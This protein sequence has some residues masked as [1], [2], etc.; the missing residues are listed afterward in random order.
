MKRVAAAGAA[1]A[2]VYVA[3]VAATALFTDRDVRPLFDAIGPTPVYRWVKPPPDFAPG[4]IKPKPIEVSFSLKPEDPPPAGAS[5]DQQLVFSLP[6]GTLALT[7]TDDRAVARIEPVDPDSLGPLPAGT[8]ADGNAYHVT[9]R[10]STTNQL[11]AMTAPGSVLLTVPVPATEVHYSADGRS[12]RRV[13]SRHASANTVGAEM[14][15]PGYFVAVSPDAVGFSEDDGG[16]EGLVV[17]VG[18]TVIVAA[19]LVGAP[20]IVRRRRAA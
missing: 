13:L 3:V 7:P 11:A 10:Y 20:V 12:W 1:A 15:G 18:V 4:N 8:F 19:V 17:P 16:F 5:E 2:L 14:P 6:R 9:F